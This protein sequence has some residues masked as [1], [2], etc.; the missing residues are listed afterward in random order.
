M[1]WEGKWQEE[2]SWARGGDQKF[3]LTKLCLETPIRY[4]TGETNYR[5]IPPTAVLCSAL[6]FS[7]STISLIAEG[8]LFKYVIKWTDIPKKPEDSSSRIGEI[9][10]YVWVYFWYN[11]KCTI[12]PNCIGRFN[13]YIIGWH[14]DHT[15][16]MYKF[17][18][19]EIEG[20]HH[21][22]EL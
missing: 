21:S 16:K 7:T 18:R 22:L 10:H 9:A 2:Q 19:K 6:S 15:I 20:W 14:Q 4:L 12:F 3:G 1:N 5:N 17:S 13:F 8:L 11:S